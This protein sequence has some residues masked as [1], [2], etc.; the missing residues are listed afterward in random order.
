L[1]K[2]TCRANP[3]PSSNNQILYCYVLIKSCSYFTGC[4]SKETRISGLTIKYLTCFSDINISPVWCNKF[5]IF[6]WKCSRMMEMGDPIKLNNSIFTDLKNNIYIL[7]SNCCYTSDT[8]NLQHI[9]MQTIGNW[10]NQQLWA[11]VNLPYCPYHNYIAWHHSNVYY[12][13]DTDTLFPLSLSE[14]QK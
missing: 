5:E 4:S 13:F 2:E 9:Y 7:S 3:V 10:Q 14:V 11:C 12:W 6:S 1:T 8:S